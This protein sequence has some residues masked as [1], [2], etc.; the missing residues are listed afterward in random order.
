MTHSPARIF[1][2]GILVGTL[3][4][5]AAFLNTWLTSGRGPD[6]VLKFVASGVFGREAFA[7]GWNMILLGLLFHYIIA[8]A[9]TAFFFL[10][11]KQLSQWIPNWLLLGVAYGLFVWLVMNRLVVPLSN[12]PKFPFNLT[13][14]LINAAI[15]VV[16]I[17]LPLSWIAGRRRW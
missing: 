12:T 6:A 13:S 1:K 3:D 10:I 9:F 5:A 16:C 15:L 11:Y 14:V 17:G 4:I 7:G 2:A 8:M